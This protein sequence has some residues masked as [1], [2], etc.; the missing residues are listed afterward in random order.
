MKTYLVGGAV[1][2][3]LLGQSPRE[4]DWVLV[5]TTAEEVE[6]QGYRRVGKA[7]P[8]YLHPLTGEEYSLARTLDASGHWM[9]H[10]QISIQEDLAHRD[11]TINA[12]ARDEAG[13]LI[14]PYG[15]QKDL[16]QR[17]L[18][19][20]GRSFTLDPVRLLRVARLAAQLAPWPFQLAPETR[21]LMQQMAAMSMLKTLQP[22]R[23]WLELEKALRA[24]APR[25][26]LEILRDTGALRS[27]FPELDRLWG[28]PQTARWHPEID[29]GQHLLLVMEQI[30]RLSEDPR[31]RFAALV[32]DLGKGTT[33]N[34]LLPRHHGHEG[35]SV[36][37][38]QEM[39]RRLPIPGDFF[40]LAVRVARYHGLAHKLEELSPA[41]CVRLFE[42][43]DAFRH[44]WN[45]AAY[46]RVCEADHRG[47]QGFADQDYSQGTILQHAYTAACTVKVADIAASLQEGPA[48]GNAIHAAR[49]RAVATIG[50]LPA[51]KP[52]DTE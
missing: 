2:D 35:R 22:D 52:S 21:S 32:H 41:G 19:H 14:D 49:V 13:Q 26:F 9:F 3:Q 6:S 1:R 39:R 37:H 44:P 11:L 4:R 5:G 20:V 28:V 17:Q 45:L 47:R 42:G 51:L 36:I 46:L 38:L 15:G 40:D 7:F 50:R 33:P 18:R 24:P 48:I 31:E 34:E 27:V 12:M 8:V 23:V 25:R 16:E 10:P 30:T 43:L 29:T